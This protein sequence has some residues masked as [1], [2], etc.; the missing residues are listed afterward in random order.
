MLFDQLHG[1]TVF[2][3]IDFRLGYNQLR[4]RAPDILKTAI[5]TL[6]DN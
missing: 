3:K 2:S 6:Y 1:A 4:I 5:R